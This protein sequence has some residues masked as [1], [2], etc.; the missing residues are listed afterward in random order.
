[1][2]YRK[3]GSVEDSDKASVL[4]CECVAEHVCLVSCGLATL[5]AQET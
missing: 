1:M 5:G 4:G 3:K 2:S